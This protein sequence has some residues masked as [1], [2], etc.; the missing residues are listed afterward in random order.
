MDMNS[1]I[2]LTLVLPCVVVFIS[3]KELKA[4]QQVNPQSAKLTKGPADR[5]AG[6]VWVDTIVRDT[7]KDYLVSTVLF[8]PGARSNWHYHLGKQIIFVI[9]GDGY[10][11]AKGKPMMKLK[12]GDVVVIEPRTVHSHG[13]INGKS[14]TQAVMMNDIKRDDA[15]TWLNKVTEEEI[16]Q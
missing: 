7:I 10:Y 12:K 9:D 5:L 15:T 14:F 4:Q 2:K 6:N 16:N 13:S 8:E 3:S 1:K 11:K